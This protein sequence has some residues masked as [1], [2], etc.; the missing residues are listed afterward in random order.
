MDWEVAYRILKLDMSGSPLNPAS[1]LSA[2]DSIEFGD[3]I[4]R[5]LVHFSTWSRSD[6]DDAFQITCLQAQVTFAGR[7]IVEGRP[8]D[9]RHSTFDAWVRTALRTRL[10]DG[11]RREKAHQTAIERSQM[12]VV[13]ELVADQLLINVEQVRVFSEVKNE[14]LRDTTIPILQRRILARIP[15]D[16]M[17][18]AALSSALGAPEAT[19]R[20]NLKRLVARFRKL[21][22]TRL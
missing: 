6:F 10:A 14:I 3:L 18:P 4:R 7:P 19:V 16:G 12:P 5:M 17:S 11:Y 15:E 20:L 1:R 13:Y 21:C 9:V 2:Q 22:K 8:R